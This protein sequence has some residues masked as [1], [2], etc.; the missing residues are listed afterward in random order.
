MNCRSIQYINR[1]KLI[2]IN[3]PS[4]QPQEASSSVNGL[5]KARK[6]Y[7][8]DK[9]LFPSLYFNNFE[10]TSENKLIYLV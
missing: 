10:V 6:S 9:G 5:E 8:Q 7:L 1:V 3:T 4:G 2:Y